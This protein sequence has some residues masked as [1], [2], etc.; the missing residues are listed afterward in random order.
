MRLRISAMATG[1]RR[2]WL[3]RSGPEE[4]ILPP[5]KAN[6]PSG[7][8]I[9]TMA[10][11]QQVRVV[12]EPDWRILIGSSAARPARLAWRRCFGAPSSLSSLASRRR[13]SRRGNVV[14][15]GGAWAAIDR[16]GGVRGGVTLAEGRAEGQGPA[17]RRDKLHRRSPSLGRVPRSAQPRA[18]WRCERDAPN[19]RPALPS[20]R[21]R[22]LGMEPWPGAGAGDHRRP[23][24]R[25]EHEHRQPRLRA[26]CASPIPICWTEHRRPSTPRLRAARFAVLAKS[27]DLT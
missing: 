10:V 21:T 14:Y 9:G 23:A 11:K 15:A 4:F 22:R 7:R 16:G 3:R 25:D 13:P 18:A 19:R 8:R 1:A 24:Q 6:Q 12:N 17:D 20:R 2:T 5:L 26:A 27:S